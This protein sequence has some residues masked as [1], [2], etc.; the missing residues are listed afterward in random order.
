M[1]LFNFECDV[2]RNKRLSD[3]NPLIYILLVYVNIIHAHNAKSLGPIKA[4]F[5]EVSHVLCSASSCQFSCDL[6]S[7]PSE[8]APRVLY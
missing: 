7:P 3:S 1:V 5:H 4:W 6:P 2:T 8:A